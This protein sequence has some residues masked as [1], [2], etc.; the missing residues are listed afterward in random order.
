LASGAITARRIR[1]RGNHPDIHPVGMN[2]GNLSLIPGF[3]LDI[4][5]TVRYSVV[6]TLFENYQT[7]EVCHV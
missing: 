2:N 6:S 5:D 3:K 7:R 1:A 4:L